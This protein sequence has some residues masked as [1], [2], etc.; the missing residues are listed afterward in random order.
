MFSPP[1]MLL[2]ANLP[3]LTRNN[4]HH[5]VPA[6]PFW[7]VAR[8]GSTRTLRIKGYDASLMRVFYSAGEEDRLHTQ[9][10]PQVRGS[11]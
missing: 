8:W 5:A 7:S 6:H 11:E 9:M 1:V 3:C 10:E 2:F 4:R